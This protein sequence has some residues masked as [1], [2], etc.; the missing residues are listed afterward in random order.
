VQCLDPEVVFAKHGGPFR[1]QPSLI[2]ER[3]I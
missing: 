3:K 1:V 2:K